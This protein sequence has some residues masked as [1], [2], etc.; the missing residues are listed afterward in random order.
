MKGGKSRFDYKRSMFQIHGPLLHDSIH[1]NN[2]SLRCLLSACRLAVYVYWPYGIIPSS[3]IHELLKA[4]QESIDIL[5]DR[6]FNIIYS[7]GLDFGSNANSGRISTWTLLRF[8]NS[9][10]FYP[11]HWFRWE[12]WSLWLCAMLWNYGEAKK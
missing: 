5:S 4:Q 10:V 6:N 7:V 9:G 12:W 1:F 8:E 3:N 11:L 2:Y